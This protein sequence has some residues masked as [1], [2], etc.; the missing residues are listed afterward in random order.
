MTFATAVAHPNIALA[1]YW[2]KRDDGRHLPAVPSLSVDARGH[3]DRD[4]RD[5]RLG[6]LRRRA[7]RQRRQPA[8]A[9]R[10]TALLDRVRARAGSSARARVESANDFPTAAGLASSASAFAALAVAGD[11]RRRPRRDAGRAQRSRAPELGLR[12][13]QRVRRVRRAPR[14][15]GWG[16]RRCTARSPSRPSSHWDL[17]V[18][19]AVTREEAKETSSTAGHAAH[20]A[21]EPVL[22]RRGSP[23]RPPCP[24]RV[25]ARR[26]PRSRSRGARRR[27]RGERAPHARRRD[28]CGARYRLLERRDRR[29]AGRG[30]APARARRAGVRDDR[31]RT[32]REGADG[33]PTHEAAVVRALEAVPG[34][35]RTIATRPG[36]GARVVS[37]G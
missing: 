12:G 20:A 13:A 17:R 8:N 18:V 5:L 25:R 28:R 32:A 14:G 34:V 19:V 22:R 29:G 7:R 21:H 11:G 4:D 35:L 23:T 30:A 9:V 37:R 1:K 31:R 33:P 16:R 10:A 24:P 15:H 26:R 36:E 6:A 27:R 2:G 3:E